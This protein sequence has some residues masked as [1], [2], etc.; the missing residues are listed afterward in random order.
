M[1]WLKDV[2]GVQKPIIAMCH[3]EPLPG[4][5]GYKHEKGVEW[6]VECARKNL[7]AL[8]DGG[9]DAVMFSNEQSLPYLTKVEPITYVTMA[10]I[11]GELRREVKVPFGVNVLWDP[12]ASIDLAVA[13][14]GLFV[15]EIFSGVYAS[16]FGLWNTSTGEVIRHQHH[17]HGEKVKL[18]FNIVPEAAAYL[19]SRTP[20]DIARSTVFNHRPDALCVSGLV[21]GV[22]ANTDTLKQV[23]E[24]VPETPVFANTGVRLENIAQQLA[25]ADG[26]VVGTTF[27]KDGYIWNDVDVSRV[28]EFMKKVKEIRGGR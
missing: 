28:K 20:A 12:T 19:G 11:I 22:A 14:G 8:Q 2:F 21:A 15:R 23:K 17:V 7:N 5:P 9:V 6:I 25:V 4:D 16:D 24:S 10:R 13:V 27:K 1:S 3:L 18:M 26:A